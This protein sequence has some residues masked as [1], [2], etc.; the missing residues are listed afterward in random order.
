MK[1][2][3]GLLEVLIA[4]VVLGFLIVGLNKLQ[5]GNREAVLRVRAR[6]AANFIAQH[7]LD[8]LGAMGLNSL[9]SSNGFIV[10]DQYTY[11]FE[12]KPQMDKSSTGIKAPITYTVQVKLLRD[13]KSEEIPGYP[14]TYFPVTANT[15]AKSLEATVSWEYRKS[16]QSIK[17]AKVVR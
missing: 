13:I 7:V 15:Y 6:D 5:I 1:K 17:V 16:T 3:F 2:G 4:A 14:S 9:V 10:N 11:D 8:S 12:G